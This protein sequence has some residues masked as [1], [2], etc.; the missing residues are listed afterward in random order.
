MAT[1]AEEGAAE[2]AVASPAPPEV[3]AASLAQAAR[4]VAPADGELDGQLSFDDLEAGEDTLAAAAGWTY[5]GE[6][7]GG[8]RLWF[9][10]PGTPVPG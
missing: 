6:A 5:L 9:A 2:A 3:L 7:D 10:P 8:A 1:T 4:A